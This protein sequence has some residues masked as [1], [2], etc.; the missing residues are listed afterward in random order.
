MYN[1][2]EY[3]VTG[4]TGFLGSHVVKEL[5][6]CGEKVNAL[7]LPNDKHRSELPDSVTVTAGD[8]TDIDSIYAW[9]KKRRTS[10]L[11]NTLCGNSVDS[12]LPRSDA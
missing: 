3:Y 4:A 2:S 7:V 6:K 11:F 5:I 9:L 8:V 10:L 1:Y 12:D